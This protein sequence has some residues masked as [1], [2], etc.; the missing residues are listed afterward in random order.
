MIYLKNIRE[1]QKVYIPRTEI[2]S[3]VVA[4]KSYDEGYADGIV[5]GKKLQKIKLTS[6]TVSENGVYKR[7]D[8]WNE[9]EID[10]PEITFEAQEKNITVS[11]DITVVQPDSGYDGLS[12]V[13]VNATQYGQNK[14]NEGYT[15][16]YT[17]G[18]ADGTEEGYQ[19]GKQDG[20]TEGYQNGYNTGKA[21]GTEEGYS[22]G[23]TDGYNEGKKDG[24]EEG[25]STGISDGYAD[26]KTDGISEQKRKL[27]NLSVTENGIY[28][29]TDGWNEI[30]VNVQS[31]TLNLQQ[32]HIILSKDIEEVFPDDGYDALTKVEIDATVFGDNKFSDGHLLGKTEGY[33]TGYEFGKA[34]GIEEGYANGY[35]D[36]KAE[37]GDITLT[38]LIDTPMWEDRNPDNNVTYNPSDYNAN[39]FSTVSIKVDTLYNQGKSEGVEEGY[40]SGYS[41]GK[42]DGIEEGYADGKTEGITEQKRRLTN[43]I[44]NEN[45]TYT[46]EDGYKYVL[47]SVPQTNYKTTTKYLR[48]TKDSEDVVADEGFAFTKVTVNAT[49]YGQT[50][51]DLGYNSGYDDGYDK[52]YDVGSSIQKISL[53]N[54]TKF[55]YSTFKKLP[56]TNLDWDGLKDMSFMFYECKNLEEFYLVDTSSV[57][58]MYN[59]FYGCTSLETI[60]LIDTSNVTNMQGA[61]YACKNLIR[62]S[63][64]DTSNVTN[65]DS[66]FWDCTR[67]NS[68]PALDCSKLTS[69]DNFFGNYTITN[70]LFFGGFI[71]LKCKILNDC[72]EKAPNLTIPSCINVLN[73]LYDFTG[74]G[75]TPTSSQGKLKVHQNFLDNVGNQISIATK[76]GWTITA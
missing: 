73:G 47:V 50:K 57:T 13:N 60:P 21:D 42:T 9:V 61:F 69:I 71:N 74:N 44:V 19:S 23:K 25:Y 12:K 46:R 66:M 5:E 35:A 15:D 54:G 26:G 1:K 7:E 27:T 58:T 72:L 22:Q 32:K 43:L 24:I 64:I 56:L 52:G 2:N 45:G 63:E 49:D 3:K 11:K 76:K 40:Q 6:L 75:E 41:Q 51:Y 31:K 67:L 8:G 28:E 38:P 10:V 34:D 14:R 62:I 18:K 37:G 29:R 70:L 30:N 68:L 65:M 55:A 53:K 59:A 20:I 4:V 17:T 36:G 39:G 16:G 33:D 48:V